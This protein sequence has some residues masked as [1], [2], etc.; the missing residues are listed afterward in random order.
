MKTVSRI[1]FSVSAL[2]LFFLITTALTAQ[3]TFFSIS[4]GIQRTAYEF[5]GQQ[6]YPNTSPIFPLTGRRAR[7]GQVV[8]AELTHAVAKHWQ[9][10]TGLQFRITGYAQETDLRWP[11]E[12]DNYGKYHPYLPKERLV[13]NHL[14]LEIPLLVQYRFA[15]KRA[16]PYVEAGVSTNYYLTTEVKQ[17]IAGE[18]EKFR[19]RNEAINPVN[20][21]LRC[22]AGIQ[23]RISKKHQVFLQQVLRYQ[24][25]RIEK[26]SANPGLGW[27]VEAGWMLQLKG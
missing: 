26:N 14:F 24:A 22:A 19:Q 18:T 27:G 21:A 3:K 9:L 15:E 25:G 2:L 10:K 20:A 1:T 7:T 17:R 8:G 11:S 12:H 6:S 5:D 13:V 16:T 23:Y 4:V